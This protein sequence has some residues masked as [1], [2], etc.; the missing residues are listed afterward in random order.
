MGII[1]GNEGVE[2][3]AR[4]SM[5][6]VAQVLKEEITRLARKEVKSSTAKLRKDTVELKRRIADHG[7]RIASLERENKRLGKLVDAGRK[8]SVK[9]SGDEVQKARITAKMIKSI[10]GKFKLSQADFAKL[11]GVAPLTI[12]QWEKKKGRLTFRG[13]SKA[14]IVAVRKL[15]VSEVKK[16]LG[17]K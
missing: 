8:A 9:V 3:P 10:R 6:N 1:E 7:R 13:D 11:L 15:T 2:K 16:R 12:Y 4:R 17:K 5:P 14:K